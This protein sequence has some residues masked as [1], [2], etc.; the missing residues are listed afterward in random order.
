MLLTVVILISGSAA[1]PYAVDWVRAYT[2][3]CTH[4]SWAL[5]IP[6]TD[7][8]TIGKNSPPLLGVLM[9]DLGSGNEMGADQLFTVYG[10]AGGGTNIYETYNITIYTDGFNDSYGPYNGWDSTSLNFYTPSSPQAAEWR[11]IGIT[12]TYGEVQGGNQYDTIYGPEINA[13]GY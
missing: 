5:G 9:L 6:D 8:A 10:W 4:E 3:N 13:V 2:T 7:N 11:Y 12:G 1:A